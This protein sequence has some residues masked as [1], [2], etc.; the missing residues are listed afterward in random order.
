[1]PTYTLPIVQCNRAEVGVI[2]RV[3]ALLAAPVLLD[4]GFY[5]ISMS[6]G[7]VG[8]WALDVTPSATVGSIIASDSSQII[9]VPTR[10]NWFS[11][12]SNAH[13]H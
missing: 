5:R 7:C 10:R 13:L 12:F 8:T 2:V 9:Y 1:M 3:R 11:M 4:A 6:S